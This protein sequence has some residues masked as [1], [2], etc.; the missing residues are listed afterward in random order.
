MRRSG[1]G[2]EVVAPLRDNYRVVL[3]DDI[4]GVSVVQRADPDWFYRNEGGRFVAEPLAGNPRFVDERG[5]PLEREPDDFGLAARFFD[6]N[7]DGAPDLYVAND[8][9]D[10]DQFWLNDGRGGFRLVDARAVRQTSNS[11]MAVDAADFDRDGDV[12]VFEVDMLANDSHRRKTQIPTHTPL[13]KVVGDYDRRAQW[14]R[15]VLLANR[16]DGTFAEIG[17]Q[18]GVEASGWSWSAMFVDA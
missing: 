16:G 1:T 13:P 14:Q 2:F 7:G 8:F 4:R 10:P 18:A 5:T 11:G 12:D 3:R 6:V 9:E 17:R 15:N